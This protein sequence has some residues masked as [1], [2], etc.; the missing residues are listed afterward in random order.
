MWIY[1]V[2]ISCKSRMLGRSCGK[3]RKTLMFRSNI[4][5]DSWVLNSELGNSSTSVS[6]SSTRFGRPNLELLG[7]DFHQISLIKCDISNQIPHRDWVF[8]KGWILVGCYVASNYLKSN[9][10]EN[11]FNRK[12]MRFDIG[13]NCLRKLFQIENSFNQNSWPNYYLIKVVTWEI[14]YERICRRMCIDI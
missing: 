3:C 2:F 12:S 7:T 11:Y 14:T 5:V 8:T 10:F 9:C 6:C 13:S 4:L 1:R